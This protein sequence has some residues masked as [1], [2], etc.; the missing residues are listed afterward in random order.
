MYLPYQPHTSSLVPAHC[1]EERRT[2]D[3][4]PEPAWRDPDIDMLCRNI[5]IKYGSDHG[6]DTL[7]PSFSV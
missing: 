4:V 3:A 5:Q 1:K 6:P 2:F 7:V